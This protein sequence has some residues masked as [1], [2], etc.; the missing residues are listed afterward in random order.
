LDVDPFNKGGFATSLGTYRIEKG[1]SPTTIIGNDAD[2]NVVDFGDETPDFEMGFSNSFTY[3]NFNLSFLF[4]LKQGGDIINLGR[5]LTD[6]GQVS[7]DFEK[8]KVPVFADDGT[9]VVGF[10][11]PRLRGD[12]GTEPWIE[13]GTYLKL[14]E[15]SLTYNVDREFVDSWFNGLVSSLNV[16]ISGRNLFVITDY[17]GYDPEVSNF[18]NVAIGRSVDVIPFP[19][20]RSVYFNVSLGLN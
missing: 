15:A 1:K 5:F 13:D 10:T 3:G 6:L 7:D 16:G 17:S 18:G 14:R 4:H 19:S 12:F 20:A 9:T 2:G 8:E 11:T